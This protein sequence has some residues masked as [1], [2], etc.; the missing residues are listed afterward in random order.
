MWGLY[1][2]WADQNTFINNTMNYND[3]DGF[4][5]VSSNFLNL[6]LNKANHNGEKGFYIKYCLGMNFTLNEAINNNE[7]GVYLEDCDYSTFTNNTINRNL[8]YGIFI[9]LYCNY[10]TIKWNIL[11]Y[12]M[13]AIY[14][15]SYCSCIIIQN[16]DIK[17]VITLTDGE[18]TPLEGDDSTVFIY[19]VTYT[20][21]DDRAP[22]S[23]QVIIDLVPHEMYKLN[24]SDDVYTDGCIYTFNITFSSGSHTYAFEA[25]DGVNVGRD[26]D[27]GYHQGP[28]ITKPIPGF[29]NILLIFMIIAIFSLLTKIQPLKK[30]K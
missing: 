5:A 29:T 25:S 21:V 11:W 2:E 8:Q 4:T 9:N 15:E 10:I 20:N 3:Y 30:D 13:L 12:N 1:V 26:P 16:N 6:T 14:R 17:S 19:T 18:V 7:T 28:S 24:S 27:S 23:I 22:I